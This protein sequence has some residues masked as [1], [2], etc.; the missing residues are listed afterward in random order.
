MND[1]VPVARRAET[2]PRGGLAGGAPN[3]GGTPPPRWVT[4]QGPLRPPVSPSA[5]R[6]TGAAS[7]PPRSELP[8]PL[9]GWTAHAT[10]GA[11]GPTPG[12]TAQRGD[13][14]RGRGTSKVASVSYVLGSAT[15]TSRPK[16]GST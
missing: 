9:P 15:M 8:T 13:P 6:P 11:R 16:G 14:E 2:S 4:V 7:G 10:L 1:P 5:C 3:P 12:P